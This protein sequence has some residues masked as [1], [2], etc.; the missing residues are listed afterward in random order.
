[1]KHWEL[2]YGLFIFLIIPTLAVAQ[3]FPKLDK[4]SLTN[5]NGQVKM[6]I[7]LSSGSICN[8]IDV[9]RSTDSI[10]FT[11]IGGIPGFCGSFDVPTDYQYTDEKPIVNATNYYY[12]DFGGLGTSPIQSINIIGLNQSGYRLSPNPSNTNVSLYFNNTRFSEFELYLY[13][14]HGQIVLQQR[15]NLDF[16][17]LNVSHLLSGIYSFSLLDKSFNQIINGR[18]V[19]Q[20]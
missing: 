2:K 7:R 3:L 10:N 17:N 8:G 14:T 11:Y 20:H 5:I 9:Y 1:M 16:I 15:T 13:N 19:V 4:Y 18:I 12:L 6:D